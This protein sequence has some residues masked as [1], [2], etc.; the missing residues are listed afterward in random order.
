M[1]D[2]LIATGLVTA[3]GKSIFAK[4]SDRHPNEAQQLLQIPAKINEPGS[5]LQCTYISIPQVKETHAVLLSQPF[6]MWGAEIG[7]N[8]HGL[9]IG[10]EAIFS[11]IPANKNPA[12]L[13]MDLL[14]LGLERAVTPR[15]AVNVIVELLEQFGQGG[16][17]TQHGK[18]YYHNSFIIANHEDAWVLE[19][20]DKHWVARQVKD[21][22]S[23][24]N[25]L[26]IQ[27]EWDWA[28]ESLDKRTFDFSKKYSDFIY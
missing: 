20:V 17:C 24:S 22:Y 6:W 3:R 13:G 23:I 26:T 18:L 1:C 28:S 8:E 7:V 15:E 10:N 16:N 14:R 4:N 12:L 21:T 5:K 25:C 27:G 11:K 9:V 2:T 19:A